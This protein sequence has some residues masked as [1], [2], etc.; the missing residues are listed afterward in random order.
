MNPTQHDQVNAY[1]EGMRQCKMFEVAM[2]ASG[3][4]NGPTNNRR[5]YRWEKIQILEKKAAMFKA[6][7]LGQRHI[8]IRPLPHNWVLLDLD[9]YTQDTYRRALSY[10]P[11]LVVETSEGKFQFHYRLKK[12]IT[13]KQAENAQR[14]ITKQVNG[15]RF[16]I[17]SRQ[18]HRL[19]GY[20]NRKKGRAQFMTKVVNRGYRKG[21]AANVP[22]KAYRPQPVQRAAAAT[23]PSSQGSSTGSREPL[24]ETQEKNGNYDYAIAMEM[25]EKSSGRQSETEYINYVEERYKQQRLNIWDNLGQYLTRTFGR[26]KENYK[27]N[28][29]WEF[30]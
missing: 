12:K 10:D 17:G 7:T 13:P 3:S 4:A 20:Y 27:Q 30:V 2:I 5:H 23:A 1:L 14:W 26:A 25:L 22:N 8:Y 6:N 15:D 18:L 11:C 28:H 16:A 29:P 21:Q 24:T 19:P 9:E